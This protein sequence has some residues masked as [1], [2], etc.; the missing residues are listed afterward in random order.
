M[1]FDPNPKEDLKDF[2]NYKEELKTIID[3][4]KRG[5]KV[6]IIKGI[7]RTGK[8][9]LMKVVKNI[10]RENFLCEYIDARK[11]ENRS[12][13]IKY[14]I[15][16]AFSILKRLLPEKRITELISSITIFGVEIKLNRENTI[17]IFET[18]DDVLKEKNKRAVI[19]IDEIQRMKKFGGD[20]LLA[21]L[22]DNT[23]KITFVISGSEVG[24]L[25]EFCGTSSEAPLYGRAKEVVELRR[26]S[27]EKAKEFLEIGAKQIRK[28]IEEKELEEVVE[29]LDGIIGWL[30]LYGYYRRKYTHKKCLSLVAEEGKKIVEN[31]LNNFLK[32]KE[33]ARK[34]Y[35]LILF[36]ISE[37]KNW[38]EIKAFLEL[39]LKK[40]VSESR[41]YSYLQNLIDYG[42]VEEKD[43]KYFYTDPLIRE[44]V[45]TMLTQ[46]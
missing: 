35:L 38:S 7:R 42:F 28:K 13:M 5:E 44:A 41:L 14:F 26:L 2:Y 4:I 29:R 40:R 36:S 34:K 25:E 23:K 1:Y 10:L 31:E 27:T 16:A 22:Y 12:E 20:S 17:E 15:E 37:P 46:K 18:L 45:S 33:L 19:F 6:I 21:Y 32:N 3:S 39:H 30:S 9:S 24:I 11:V 43:K 8:T